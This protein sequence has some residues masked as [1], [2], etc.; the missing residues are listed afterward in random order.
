MIEEQKTVVATPVVKEA[1]TATPQAIPAIVDSTKT[2]VAPIGP[3][4]PVAPVAPAAPV[5]DKK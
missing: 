2:T 5:V 4:A 3:V 1:V